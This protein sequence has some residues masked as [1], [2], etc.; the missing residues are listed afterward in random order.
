MCVFDKT[1]SRSSRS[2]NMNLHVNFLLTVSKSMVSTTFDFVKIKHLSLLL[3]NMI[4]CGTSDACAWL[5][6]MFPTYYLICQQ[7]EKHSKD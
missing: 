3:T 5:K 6:N 4:S 7:K 2:L 1:H